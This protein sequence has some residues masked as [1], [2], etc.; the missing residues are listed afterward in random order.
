[1][2]EGDESKISGISI[3]VSASGIYFENSEREKYQPGSFYWATPVFDVDFDPPASMRTIDHWSQ[4]SQPAR[5]DGYG[6]NGEEHW[7]WLD[8]EQDGEN[9]WPACWV[10]PEIVNPVA[11]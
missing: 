6:P 11:P 2:T 5:F 10:G 9:W 7:H 8:V 4:K 3:S 1:M